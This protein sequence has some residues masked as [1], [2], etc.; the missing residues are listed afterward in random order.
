[1]SNNR[2]S[3]LNKNE[4]H[5]IL[6]CDELLKGSERELIYYL[7]YLQENNKSRKYIS[8]VDYENIKNIRNQI[9]NAL[10]KTN[11]ESIFFDMQDDY[12][13]FACN[14]TK[15]GWLKNDNHACFYFLLEV[16]TKGN[17]YRY[18]IESE[19][20]IN[21][22]S[23]SIYYS[24]IAFFDKSNQRVED[25][26]RNYIL[27]GILDDTHN[28]NPVF[29]WL[30]KLHDSDEI[31]YCL[32]YLRDSV[33]RGFVGDIARDDIDFFIRLSDKYS[34]NKKH[35]LIALFE[36]LYQSSRSG[37]LAVENLKMKMANALS[38]WK[39]RKNKEGYVDVHFDIKKENIPKL[40]VL[41]KRF[42]LMSKK[43]VVN[44]LIEREYDKKE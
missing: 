12:E 29:P 44:A 2:S 5:F 3:Y 33:K 19:D 28:Q 14:E 13:E 38:S 42:N 27:E 18:K 11:D 31:K 26:K 6:K 8:N 20:Y 16:L 9:K 15:F 40:E 39:N 4:K 21:L 7:H 43:E 36:H 30:S 35:I 24:I 41:K 10:M 37:D 22:N 25:Y 32:N 1:M 23:N 34:L 17:S